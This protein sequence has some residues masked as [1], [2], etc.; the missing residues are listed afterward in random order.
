LPKFRKVVTF[1]GIYNA[2]V[3]GV[4]VKEPVTRARIARWV[5][6]FHKMR[7]AQIQVPMPWGHQSQANPLK[8]DPK[9]NSKDELAFRKSRFNASY[10]DDLEVGPAGEMVVTGEIPPGLKVNGGA[11]VDEKNH[12]AI[13]EVSLAANSWTDGDGTKW[14]DCIRHIAFTPLPVA[15]KTPGFQEGTPAKGETRFSIS[16]LVGCS[17]S[18]RAV[19]FAMAH[20]PDEDKKPKFPPKDEEGD[21]NDL[22]SGGIDIDEIKSKLAS[23]MGIKLPDDTNAENFLE[24]LWVAIHALAPDEPESLTE[25][26]P[27]G[28]GMGTMMSLLDNDDPKEQRLVVAGKKALARR[29]ARLVHRGLRPTAAKLLQERAAVPGLQMSIDNEGNIHAR[30]LEFS[31]SL[32]EAH[33]P[34]VNPF[35][36]SGVNLSVAVNPVGEDPTTDLLEAGRKRGAEISN[37]RKTA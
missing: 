29:I 31:L 34:K 25:E 5:D 10:I 17:P 1:P 8:F 14:D 12:T 33:L 15:H 27:P 2:V 26:T 30:G 35:K 36:V 37:G 19:E 22:E 11:L 23:A 20:E 32:L 7:D 24:H 6:Q 3:D 13:R 21:E 28:G 9:A 16:N 4:Q 18:A